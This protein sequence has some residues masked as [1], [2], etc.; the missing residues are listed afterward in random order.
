MVAA[1]LQGGTVALSK[2]DNEVLANGMYMIREPSAKPAEDL[3]YSNLIAWMQGDE[4]DVHHT[5]P[6]TTSSGY[7]RLKRIAPEMP[8]FMNFSGGHVVGYQERNW[9]HPYA[10]WL[11][12]ADWSGND[13]YPVAGWNLPRRLGLVGYAIDKLRAIAPEKPQFAFIE[14]SDQGLPWNMDAPGPTVGQF[15]TEIWNAVIHGARGIIYFADQFKPKFSYNA[16]TAEIEAEMIAQDKVLKELGGVLLSKI[17]PRGYGIELPA[18]MEGTVRVFKGKVYLIVLNMSSRHVGGA[19]IKLSGVA[20]GVV[21]VY[22]EGRSVN[23]S[24]GEIV[25]DFEGYTPRIYVVG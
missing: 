8:V 20:D 9:K 23:I 22:G 16:M 10:A 15:R 3:K 2:W 7:E 25:E 17:D 24:G 1:E 5:D 19:R 12:G 4:P 6:K 11:A 18:G 14:A 13:I 21:E